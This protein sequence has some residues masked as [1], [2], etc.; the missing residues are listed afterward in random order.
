MCDDCL[1]LPLFIETIQIGLRSS[2]DS[3]QRLLAQ[4]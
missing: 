2:S 3:E 4:S 1:E